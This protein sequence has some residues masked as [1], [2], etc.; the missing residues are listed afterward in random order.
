ME[1]AVLLGLIVLNGLFAMSEVALLT[2]RKAR[3]QRLV[4]EGDKSAAAALALGEDPTRFLS[5]IQIGI[6]SIGVL[7]GI[8]G[9][10]AFAE[11]LARWLL[12]LGVAQKTAEMLATTLVVVL[13]TY[14]AIV[15][16][17]LV[18]KRLGQISAETV[19]RLAARPM[20]VLSLVSRPFVMALTGSTNLILR[21]MGVDPDTEQK[22]TEEEIH[23][24]L[25][26]GSE[27]GVI[28]QSE[29][30][31]VR[32]VFRLD[33]RQISSLMVPRSDVVY[34]DVEDPQEENLQKVAE[35]EHSRFPVCRGGLDDVL[36][37]IHTKQLLAQ[38][39]RG[40]SIDFSQNLQEV[41]YVP[42]TLTGMELLENIRN[43]N[44]QIALVLDEYGEV[45]GL[46]TLQDLLEAIT[47]EFTSP[48]DDDSWALQRADGS[49]LLDGLIPIPE[50]KDRL[51]LA[52]VPEEDKER[53]QALSGMMM[54]LLGRMPQT[55][56]ILTWDKWKFEVVDMDGKRI[57]KVLATPIL[58]GEDADEEDPDVEHD[59][60]SR[61]D[62]DDPREDAHPGHT[63]DGA[64]RHDGDSH[65]TGHH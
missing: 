16:G 21:S 22:V 6:T 51:N 58:P 63:E 32:N 35:Y 46:V 17:E 10:A 55:G 8:V 44:T 1:A 7:N 64:H 29:H 33:E 23:A 49:W 59:G 30:V 3:L 62:G 15:V 28:E 25:A 50:L 24:L 27:S 48:D 37:I 12:S 60:H 54:L 11:P 52:T 31:M 57:D 34:L 19:A 43:S 41:L 65:R 39:L 26:E 13:V 36:G 61:F 45:Q 56:D 20:G 47:G 2:A 53:Y 9:Q 14:V 38:S 40:E 18:P 4:A 42:E 5:T